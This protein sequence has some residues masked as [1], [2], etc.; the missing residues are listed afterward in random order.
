VSTDV[1]I[2]LSTY[3]GERYLPELLDSI[4]NQTYPDLKIT[5]RDDGSSDNTISIVKEFA[6]VRSGVTLIRGTNIG[7]TRSFFALLSEAE[8]CG[9]YAFCDQDDVWLP[10]KVE[11]AV[12]AINNHPLDK[13]VMYCSAHELVDKELRPIGK[14]IRKKIRPGF[15][16]ALVEN[17]AMGCTIVLNNAA[18]DKLIKKLPQKALMHD[19]WMYMVI[20][21]F[22]IVTYDP[23]PSILYRQHASNVLGVKTTPLGRWVRRIRQY[24]DR[25]SERL[26]RRQ[27]CEFYELYKDEMDEKTLEK[28]KRFLDDSFINRVRN[29]FSSTFY[30]QTTIDNLIFKVLYLVNRI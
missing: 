10:D 12:N 17:N 16:N 2:L 19:W 28:T 13:P 3:N 27:V 23:V 5:I 7:I 20:S 25:G 18:R 21:A 14:S 30:R 29:L 22:G 15:G 6:R 24:K 26:I 9:Y 1:N 4:A 8:P 11:R